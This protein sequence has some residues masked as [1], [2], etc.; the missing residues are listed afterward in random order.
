MS[1]CEMGE[2]NTRFNELNSTMQMNLNK[3]GRD[4]VALH[5]VTTRNK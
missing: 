1:K 2:M 5:S 4:T 3:I